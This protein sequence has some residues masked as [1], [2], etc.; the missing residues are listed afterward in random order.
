MALRFK[1]RDRAG[2]AKANGLLTSGRL[3]WLFAVG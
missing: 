2:K 1:A 3:L